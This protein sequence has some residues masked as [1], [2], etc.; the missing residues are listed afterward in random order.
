M[1]DFVQVNSKMKEHEILSRILFVTFVNIQTT[2][3]PC[4]PLY[5]NNYIPEFAPAFFTIINERHAFARLIERL[6]YV[7]TKNEKT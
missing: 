2:Q 1:V 3:D 6:K 4:L 5:R 7:L